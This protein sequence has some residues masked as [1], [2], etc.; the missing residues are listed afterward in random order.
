MELMCIFV[1]PLCGCSLWLLSLLSGYR[2]ITLHFARSIQTA[3][4]YGVS[5]PLSRLQACNKSH[6][7]DTV[8]SVDMKRR[9]ITVSH[10]RIV[11]YISI[12]I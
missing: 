9:S 6:T 3:V 8:H 4:D 1:V 2:S 11:Q 5:I 12:V 7:I 10:P